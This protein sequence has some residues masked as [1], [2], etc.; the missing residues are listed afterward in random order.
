M[1][2]V[3]SLLWHMR[4]SSETKFPDQGWN[5]G[6]MHWEHGPPGKSLMGNVINN[7]SSLPCLTPPK[8]VWETPSQHL[9]ALTPLAPPFVSP[10]DPADLEKICNNKSPTSVII[11][12]NISQV[13][14]VLRLWCPSILQQPCEDYSLAICIS[15][16]R[17]NDTTSGIASKIF[18]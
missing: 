18:K 4:P 11:I 1:Q 3:G 10:L 6:P 17:W 13:I 14:C 12:T 9:K 5:L 2:H 15:F 7:H 8:P 16:C